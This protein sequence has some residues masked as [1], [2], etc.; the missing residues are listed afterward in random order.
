M[1][2]ESDDGRAL[3]R[4]GLIERLEKSAEV[5]LIAATS[6][7]KSGKPYINCEGMNIKMF[8][9]ETYRRKAAGYQRPAALA[10]NAAEWRGIDPKKIEISYFSF[11]FFSLTTL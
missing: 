8:Q 3:T 1:L 7:N 5:I 2:Q 4:G 11:L 10:K 9:N 6:L